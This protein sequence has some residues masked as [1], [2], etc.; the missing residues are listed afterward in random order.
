MKKIYL[1]GMAGATIAC[2]SVA[3]GAYRISALEDDYDKVNETYNKV[4]KVCV[5]NTI[6]VKITASDTDKEITEVQNETMNQEEVFKVDWN[7]LKSINEDTV[8]WIKIDGTNINYPIVQCDN[9][10]KYVGHDINGRRSKGGCIFVD[11]NITN[12]FKNLNTIVYGHNLNNGAIFNDLEKYSNVQYAKQH[13]QIN[14]YLPGNEERIYKIFAFCTVS[15]TNTD[16]YNTSIINLEKYYQKVEQYNQIDIDE[17]IDYSRPV[18]M[19][20][21]CTNRERSQRYVVFAYLDEIK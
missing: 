5:E 9:N 1:L 19:L 15:E 2:I 17:N 4:E 21:T 14:I 20:S 6:P 10:S 13:N 12:P 8:A 7:E 18:I 11:C 3:C 16:I